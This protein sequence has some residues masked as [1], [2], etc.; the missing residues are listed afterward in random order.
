LS[1]A[2]GKLQIA[3]LCQEWLDRLEPIGGSLHPKKEELGSTD[4]KL[5]AKWRHYLINVSNGKISLAAWMDP[6]LSRKAIPMDIF[7]SRK[8]SWLN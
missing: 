4:E 8:W 5:V 3:G 2:S 1:G 6:E 7:T